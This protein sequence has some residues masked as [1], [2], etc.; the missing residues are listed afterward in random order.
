MITFDDLKLES[1]DDAWGGE[2]ATVFFENGYGASVIYW[3]NYYTSNA[4]EFE[5]A[6]L[7]GKADSFSLTYETDITSDVLGHLSKDAV[8]ETLQA[9]QELP[10]AIGD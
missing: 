7:I 2:V 6:V 3:D 10:N 8:T 4:N 1:R 5:V 9:I